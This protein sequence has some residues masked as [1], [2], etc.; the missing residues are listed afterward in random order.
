MIDFKQIAK[1]SQF[2]SF[3][4]HTPFCDGHAPI[5]DFIVEA[6]S[7]RFT[8]YGVSPHSPLP[9]S[10]SANMSREHVADYL[11]EMNRLKAEYG[12]QIHLFTSMEVDFLDEWGP[13]SPYFQNLPLDY[14]IGSVHFIPSFNSDEYVDIDGDF[15]NFSRKMKR[16]FEGDIER[17]VRSFY[18]Q[19]EK[20]VEMGGFDIIGHF[21]KI[22][23]NASLYCPGIEEQPWYA[24]LVER[25]FEAIMD[26]HLVIE[27]N[28][29]KWV[30]DHRLFPHVRYFKMLKRYGAP[31]LF[32]SDAHFP[33]FI[34]SG[35]MEAMH[36]YELA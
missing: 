22:G 26:H 11:T 7:N 18:A 35:R 4:N 20:M 6:I 5:E 24:R 13:S 23:H 9:F 21:D 17:V 10:S 33:Q 2:Y 32:N 28:T 8:H 3:H 29:K 34:N 1:D 36:C 15:Q 31:V 12:K 14:R 16:Y 19:S 30:T 25:L 27:I